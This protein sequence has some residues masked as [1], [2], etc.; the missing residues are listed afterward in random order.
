MKKKRSI[1]NYWQRFTFPLFESICIRDGVIL[2][3]EGH[4]QRFLRSYRSLYASEPAYDLFQG[5]RLRPELQGLYKLR[6]SYG[7]HALTHTLEPYAPRPI[8]LLR[9]LSSDSIRYEHK[10]NDRRALN[11]LLL[12]KGACDDVLIAKKGRVTDTSY[13]NI[14]FVFQGRWFTP[15][16]PLLEGTQ[17]AELIRQ[18]LLEVCPIR[19]SEI[20]EFEGFQLINAMLAFDPGSHIPITHI[21]M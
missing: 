13:S 21:K 2:N 3:P 16:T 19:V 11:R 20:P 4:R 17:R 6:I 7:R 18:H 1:V 10:R 15:D 5:I 9:L 12:K 8:Q 14:A